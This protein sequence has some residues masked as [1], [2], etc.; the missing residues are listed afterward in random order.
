MLPLLHDGG[1]NVVCNIDIIV[2]N[3]HDPRLESCG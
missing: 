3:I 1:A 2:S